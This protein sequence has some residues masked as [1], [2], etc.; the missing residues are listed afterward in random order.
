[1]ACL[2]GSVAIVALILRIGS[3]PP[4]RDHYE[5]RAKDPSA[6]R[7][8][9][10]LARKLSVLSTGSTKDKPNLEHFSGID[11]QLAKH[12]ILST[13]QKAFTQDN[14]VPRARFRSIWALFWIHKNR[15]LLLIWVHICG[16]I[17][18]NPICEAD[19]TFK[20]RIS[21]G[22]QAKPSVQLP[23]V[24][25][26]AHKP[27]YFTAESAKG[28]RLAF[29]NH[30]SYISCH[31]DT[32]LIDSAVAFIGHSKARTGPGLRKPRKKL[33]IRVYKRIP[34]TIWVQSLPVS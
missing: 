5:W 26:T 14:Q 30:H 7:G 1:M 28:F 4:V 3:D 23:M 19:S 12:V 25:G 16:Q 31:R 20:L 22:D 8:L 21:N 13:T 6:V 15:S 34:L 2:R 33:T 18:T 11:G 32:S 24:E 27:W 29:D 9:L 17:P 10:P